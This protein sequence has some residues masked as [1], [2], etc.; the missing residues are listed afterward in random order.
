[1]SEMVKYIVG[2]TQSESID[3]AIEDWKKNGGDKIIEEMN[4]VYKTMK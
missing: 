2:E 3:K 4:T 1:M